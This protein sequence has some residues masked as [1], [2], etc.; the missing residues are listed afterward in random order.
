[1][2]INKIL[3][4]ILINSLTLYILLKYLKIWI[5]FSPKT[6][7]SCEVVFTL[8]V[9]FWLI[10]DV[11]VRI[12]KFLAFPLSFLLWW[13]FAI[14]LNVAA[15]CLFVYVVN[16][17]NLWINMHVISLR[18]AFVISIIVAIFNLIFKKL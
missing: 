5:S 13:I 10:Y 11:S 1:M 6:A 2:I 12:I 3:S 7:L 9:I 16:N 4:N 15:I 18:G 8:W 17:L 14:F